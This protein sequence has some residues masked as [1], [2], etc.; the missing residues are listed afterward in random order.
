MKNFQYKIFVS[1]KE[2]SL[3]EFMTLTGK[4]EDMIAMLASAGIKNTKTTDGK[5]IKFVKY[6]E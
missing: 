1:D 6:G 3:E 4:S 2:L 5:S